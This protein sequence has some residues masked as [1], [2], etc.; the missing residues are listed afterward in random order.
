MRARPLALG[1]GSR[2]S[3]APTRPPSTYLFAARTHDMH[4]SLYIDPFLFPEAA[5]AVRAAS[6]CFAAPETPMHG[7]VFRAI[8]RHADAI[9]HRACRVPHAGD[10][11]ESLS[12]CRVLPCRRGQR[13]RNPML[14]CFRREAN[15]FILTDRFSFSRPTCGR[16]SDPESAVRRLRAYRHPIASLL[17]FR[18]FQKRTRRRTTA[19]PCPPISNRP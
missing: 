4:A 5:L 7:A 18:C 8:R 16:L 14:G 11:R 2:R 12:H 10:R 1:P 19:D 3:R 9:R 17:S 6:A 15:R 13:R